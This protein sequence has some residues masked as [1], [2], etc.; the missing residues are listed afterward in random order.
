MHEIIRSRRSEDGSRFQLSAAT[1][2]GLHLS[3]DFT[4]ALLVGRLSGQLAARSRKYLR[5]SFRDALT[6][7]PERLVVDT[8]GLVSCDDQGL[9]GLAESLDRTVPDAVP[10]AVC[11]LAPAHRDTFVRVSAERNLD[12][13]AVPS[14]QDAVQQLM[15]APG[16]PR[17]DQETLLAEV[18]NL[19]RALLTRATIDQAKGILMVVYGLDQDAAFA[20]LVWHSRCSRLPLRELAT[21]F[22][23]AVRKTPTGSLTTIRSDALLADLGSRSA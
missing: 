11:G 10:V 23:D 2:P 18:R 17:P 19:H 22:L 13:R 5:A 8:S 21:R 6:Q 14:F 3:L 15:S 16:A 1:G 20:L 4:P 9:V 12:V 7:R